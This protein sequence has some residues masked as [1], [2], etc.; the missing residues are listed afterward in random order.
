MSGEQSLPG[1]CALLAAELRELKERTGLSLAALSERT[2]YSK[3]SW[4]RYLNG[5]K[6]PPRQAVEA[7]CG[8]VDE[9]AGRLVALWEL[10]ESVW[11]G[12]AAAS[13][14]VVAASEGAPGEGVGSG[15][16]QGRS[17]RVFVL[18]ST[19]VV[20][21]A[22]APILFLT[23]GKD[24]SGERKPRGEAA[25][26]AQ[27]FEP[28]CSEIE[29]EGADPVTMGCGME[30]LFTLLTRKAAGGQRLEIRYGVK[31]GAVWARAMNLRLGD[32]VELS[33]PGAHAKEVRAVSQRDTELYLSTAMTATKE[34]RRARVCLRP[35]VGGEVECFTLSE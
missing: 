33:L 35:A 20:A 21:A 25:P 31:C 18:S 16:V 13:P 6:L 26:Y 9:P 12:R 27:L 24:A 32:Q 34:P 11:S 22:L 29:C 30:G 3:S 2:P 19:V 15:K 4:E 23:A 28:G 5:K 17:R 7:L 10:A 1:E 14:A 8:L